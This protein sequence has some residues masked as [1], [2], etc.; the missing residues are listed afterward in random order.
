MPV[1]TCPQC[2]LVTDLPVIQRSADEFCVK[3]DFPLFWASAATTVGPA[4]ESTDANL[5]RLP[6]SGGRRTVGAKTCPTCGER[7]PLTGTHCIRCG[8][9]LEIVEP[10]LHFEYLATRAA[11]VRE[12]LR[13]LKH[14]VWALLGLVVVL[15]VLGVL[16]LTHVI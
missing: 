1:I 5:R 13:E 10:E 6:G 14:Y 16:I 3:C 11:Y 8:N 4:V 9:P 2:S 7:N 12:D 15:A